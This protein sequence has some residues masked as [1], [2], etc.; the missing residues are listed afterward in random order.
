[1]RPAIEN[2]DQEIERALNNM[3]QNF[4]VD[5]ISEIYLSGSA[6]EIMHF[7]DYLESQFEVPVHFLD[8]FKNLAFHPDEEDRVN[9]SMNKSMFSSAVGIALN[10]DKTVNLLPE[11]FQESEKYRIGNKFSI[12]ISICTLLFVIGLSGWTTMN[13]SII[14]SQ[15]RSINSESKS[16]QPIKN[17]FQELTQNKATASKQLSILNDDS[18]LSRLS[19]NVM[20]FF[21]YNTPKEITLD[22]I[23]FQKGWE[24]KD[25]VHIGNSLEQ[26]ITI[27]DEDKQYTRVTGTI[28]ANPALKER[29]F[30]NF[31]DQLN[32]SGLFEKVDVINKK[33][34][35]GMEIDNMSFELKCQ[36]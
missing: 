33:T 29:Y 3:A 23:S 22:L 35:S 16:I 12:P 19:I 8:P 31:L 18:Q 24:R 32:L 27:V 21:S 1:M 30:G 7:D 5:N 20:R 15:L 34:T 10:I 6:E 13:Y 14:E 28:I 9:F 25:W 11:I 17:K 36:L 2:W 26:V 4:P